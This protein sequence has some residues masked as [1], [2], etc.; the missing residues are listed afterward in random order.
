MDFSGDEQGRK[1]AFLKCSAPQCWEEANITALLRN[2]VT[3]TLIFVNIKESYRKI[4]RTEKITDLRLSRAAT[5]LSKSLLLYPVQLF[6]KYF[7]F[8]IWHPRINLLV[9][10]F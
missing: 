3:V 8:E 10:I 5:V 4:L 6:I 9:V 7:Y 1:R 2:Q